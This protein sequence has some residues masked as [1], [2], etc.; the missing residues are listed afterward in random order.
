MLLRWVQRVICWRT[1]QQIG[2]GSVP[3]VQSLKEVCLLWVAIAV[4]CF[5]LIFKVAS[6]KSFREIHLKTLV[7]VG[8][9]LLSVSLD[10]SSCCIV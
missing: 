10:R 6:D 4:W 1:R 5:H 8:L 3:L 7:E 9:V 2:A